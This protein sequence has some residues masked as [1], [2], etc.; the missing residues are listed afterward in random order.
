MKLMWMLRVLMVLLVLMMLMMLMVL[1][2]VLDVVGRLEVRAVLSGVGVVRG[3][4]DV[5]VLSV[6]GQDCDGTVTPSTLTTSGS[7]HSVTP[8]YICRLD[9]TPRISLVSINI[10]PT[11]HLSWEWPGY[12][13]LDV[14][15]IL[16]NIVNTD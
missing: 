12:S 11:N 5:W 9:T 16:V 10:A 6:S 14:K 13:F 3:E 7:C 2:V 4:H 8:T 1:V 15:Y